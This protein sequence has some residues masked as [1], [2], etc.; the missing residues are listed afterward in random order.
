MTGSR[1]VLPCPDSE[2]R[3]SWF[4]IAS[5]AW[6]GYGLLWIFH[7]S[8]LCLFS[9]SISVF[10]RGV[11]YAVRARAQRLGI[12]GLI[13]GQVNDVKCS[14]VLGRS[15]SSPSPKLHAAVTKGMG[16]RHLSRHWDQVESLECDLDVFWKCWAIFSRNGIGSWGEA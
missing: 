8:V 2:D 7:F 10:N 13:S 14:E 16:G 3:R 1:L 12:L 4:C 15:S 11:L 9:M 6:F 5:L